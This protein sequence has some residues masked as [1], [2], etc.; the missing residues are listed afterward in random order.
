M[1]YECTETGKDKQVW[2]KVQ[3]V[4]QTW[5]RDDLYVLTAECLLTCDVGR[6]GRVPN[7]SE[8]EKD[9]V[10]FPNAIAQFT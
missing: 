7:S 5:V 10:A 3:S 4:L 9:K 1:Y 8:S 2:K 6:E